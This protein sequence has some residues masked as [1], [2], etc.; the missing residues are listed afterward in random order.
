MTG[1]I[2]RN[3]RWAALVQS[4][5]FE[6]GKALLSMKISKEDRRVVNPKKQSDVF[7][8]KSPTIAT[9]KKY[10][11][12]DPALAVVH[13]LVYDLRDSFSI[14]K[15]LSDRQ[16]ELLGEFILEDYYY[17]TIA[18]LKLC[19]KNAIKGKYG[20]VY[21]RIDVQIVCEWLSTYAENRASYAEGVST[22]RFKSEKEKTKSG[23]YDGDL[24]KTMISDLEEKL[25]KRV[26]EEKYRT[27]FKFQN[28]PDWCKANGLDPESKMEEL[29]AEWLKD[30]QSLKA[31]WLKD[32][33]SKVLNE[34][35]TFEYFCTFKISQFLI[36]KNDEK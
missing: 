26:V 33:Q 12:I 32:S 36:E 7:T 6:E 2:Q 31:E 23:F 34:E 21:D 19:F 3:D 16:L 24:V 4:G 17:L 10:Q 13:G 9:I 11:G 35:Y 1:L 18:D 30:Y 22:D 14:G 29:K 27:S 15:N 20:K 25:S 5:K 8:I 28:I